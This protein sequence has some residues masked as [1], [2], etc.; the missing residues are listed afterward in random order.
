[1]PPAA[2][3]G[4][5]QDIK[6]IEPVTEIENLRGAVMAVGPKQDL[7][8]GPEAAD[9]P[10]QPLEMGRDFGS[11]GPSGRASKAPTSRPSPSK[12]TMG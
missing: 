9:L 7:G 10:D 6:Q 8:F 4:K 12:T 1:M 5:G 2:G 11:F 3:F